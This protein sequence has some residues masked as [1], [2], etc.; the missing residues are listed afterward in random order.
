MK[1]LFVHR[2]FIVSFL[3]E[4]Q[5]SCPDSVPMDL[6]EGAGKDFILLPD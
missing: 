1:S 4:V 6:I 2:P 5:L 3:R